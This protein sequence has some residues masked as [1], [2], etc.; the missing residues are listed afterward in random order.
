MMEGT[1][2]T[3]AEAKAGAEV[4]EFTTLLGAIGDQAKS[5]TAMIDKLN[6]ELKAEKKREA[7][8]EVEER[9]SLGE[10]E[11]ESNRRGSVWSGKRQ[12]FE[13]GGGN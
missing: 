8:E 7:D 9:V 12:E 10:D 4:N 5:L 13:L 2:A 6:D 1:K 11:E 3:D